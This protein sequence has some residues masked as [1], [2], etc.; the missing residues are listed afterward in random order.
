MLVVHTGS[1]PTNEEWKTYID[2]VL[3]GGK[4]F[5]GDLRLCRQLVLSDG[6]GPNSA[7]RAMAQKAAEQMNGTQMPVAVVSASAFVRGIVTAFN[8]FNMNM[9]VFHPRDAKAALEF[10]GADALVAQEI[11]QELEEIEED[12]GPVTTVAAFREALEKDPL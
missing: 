5:G 8:W 9:K 4:H 2:T 12:L 1:A 7:Q 10:L 3:D 6:G 11:V